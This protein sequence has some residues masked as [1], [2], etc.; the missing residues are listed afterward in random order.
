VAQDNK[1]DYAQGGKDQGGG[2][3]RAPV[4]RSVTE[5]DAPENVTAETV[6][7]VKRKRGRPP[8]KVEEKARTGRIFEKK[9][10]GPI[11]PFA[12][13]V[14]DALLSLQKAEAPQSQPA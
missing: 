6:E 2:K 4:T 5:P 7:I 11:N 14:V 9:P 1:D 12:L 8:K 10:E 13:L 3:Q